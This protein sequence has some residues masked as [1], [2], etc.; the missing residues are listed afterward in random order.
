MATPA[1]IVSAYAS[2]GRLL[3]R[4]HPSRSGIAAALFM[5]LL[6]SGLEATSIGM[7]VPL[8]SSLGGDPSTGA[9]ARLLSRLVPDLDRGQAVVVYATL[10][11]ALI[12]AKNAVF[13][14]SVLLSGRLRR[15]GTVTLRRMLL[16][17][18]LHGSADALEKRS[19]GEL[20]NVFLTE[21]AR[22]NIALDYTIQL[23]QRTIMA[24]SYFAAILFIS[25][26]LTL[27]TACGGL[28][29]GV[30]GFVLSR[31]LLH[32]G[33]RLAK[34]NNE[35]ASRL[36]EVS[37]GL[38]LIRTTHSEK[39][40]SARFELVNREQAGADVAMARTSA[41]LTASVETLGVATAM[42]LVAVAYRWLLVTDQ[43]SLAAFLAFGFGVM[44]LL[45]AINQVYGLQVLI[46][47]LSSAIRPALGW[48]ELPRHPAR[49]FGSQILE[50]VRR[51]LELDDVG[52]R[53]PNGTQALRGL[54]LS[55][56]VGSFLAVV[57]ASGAGKSTLASLL[58]RLREPSSGTIRIDGRDYW[59]FEPKSYADAI[60]Y[61][62]QE[63]FVF[64]ATVAEN[65]LYG[66]PGATTADVERVL[67]MVRLDQVVA[68][69]PQGLHTVLGERGSSL[70][71]GQRQRLAIARALLRSPELIILDEPTSALDAETER[72]VLEAIEQARIGRTLIVIAHRSTTIERA[73]SILHLEE[74]RALVTSNVRAR[75]SAT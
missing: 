19:S 43:L 20:M 5:L 58:L 74:G 54:T 66:S 47:A 11:L 72:E 24:L 71:G 55:V 29:L 16:D 15:E 44:R 26:Q 13:Y 3:W 40:E 14:C 17:G 48:L 49:A 51:G 61:V 27:L 10:T 9:F 22:I 53:Y 45:P 38:R 39:A 34:A 63:P 56:P 12:A 31:R 2:L 4:L 50:K 64:N 23:T 52:Y 75:A 41:L 60:A 69:L 21:G 1:G 6:A 36:G 28:A 46:V 68:R 57:G 7:L 35:L 65:V 33:E 30:V 73:D 62:E 32:Q 37:A 67:G 70:S 18:V 59:E 8:L 25:W 42:I